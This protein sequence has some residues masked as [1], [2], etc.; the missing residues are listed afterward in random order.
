MS[1]GMKSRCRSVIQVLAV[2]AAVTSCSSGSTTTPPAAAE[3]PATSGPAPAASSR[4][5]SDFTIKAYTFPALAASAGQ[6]ITLVGGDSEPHAVTA[7]DGSFD[8]GS[9]DNAAP[10]TLTVPTKPGVYPVHCTVHPSMHGT[11]TVH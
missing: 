3:V 8:S 9:F 10:G 5:T 7:D 6:K 2:L 11:L 1:I 4:S